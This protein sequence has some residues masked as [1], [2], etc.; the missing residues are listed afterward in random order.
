MM[1]LV[2]VLCIF[3]LTEGNWRNLEAVQVHAVLL[4]LIPL[5][6]GMPG[7]AGSSRVSGKS[8]GSGM[9]QLMSANLFLL[10]SPV[11]IQILLL[12]Q[13]DKCCLLRYGEQ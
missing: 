12:Q 13:S 3:E 11:N 5:L 8:S 6:L 4:R 10:S 9:Q 7:T 1:L 2:R